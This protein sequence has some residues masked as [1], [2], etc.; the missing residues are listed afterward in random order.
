MFP[1]IESFQERGVQFIDGRIE[2]FDVAILATGYKSNV[3]YL[4]K[5]LLFLLL[6][7]YP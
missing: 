7:C 3:P 5:V 2:S 1:A 6:S 4:L